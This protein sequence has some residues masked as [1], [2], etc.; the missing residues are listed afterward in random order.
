MPCQPPVIWVLDMTKPNV[1]PD[2][3]AFGRRHGSEGRGRLLVCGP[4]DGALAEMPPVD[5]IFTSPPYNISSKGV[6]Q[7]GFRKE[8]KYDPKSFGAVRDYPD[9]L[10]E[11]E[12]QESQ[13]QFLIWA[14]Q[15]V[16]PDGVVVYNHKPRHREG[17]L[18]KPE[19]W[20]PPDLSPYDEIVWDKGGTMNHCKKYVYQCTER[21]YV[22]T[23]PGGSPYFKQEGFGDVWRI[24]R[25]SAR[26]KR[27][28]APFPLE[29][30]RRV[31]Q[32]W[33]PPG[34]VVCDPYSGSGTTM[35]AC[36]IEGRRFYGAE[37][38]ASHFDYSEERLHRQMGTLR[39]MA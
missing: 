13:R 26:E 16:K 12:Y 30:A 24:N 23:K 34:G 38:M 4:Y 39:V 31:V 27:H 19:T 36:A 11:P 9:D 18:I 5:L 28:D 10:P 17:R 2:K 8:G 33:S 32:L 1:Q 20:F 29:L 35:L 15:H 6:R 3:R 22:F 25:E 7:D 21:L 14:A 37:L